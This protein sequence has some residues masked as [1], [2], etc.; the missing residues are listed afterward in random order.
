MSHSPRTLSLA[1]V[2]ILLAVAGGGIWWRV[3]SEAPGEGEARAAE[4]DPGAL[5][6]EASQQFST[7]VAQPVGAVEV[8]RDTLWIKVTAA[9][10]AAAHRNAKLVAR[11]EGAAQ[12]VPVRENDRV[13]TGRLLVRIDS[14]EYALA[15]ARAR[16]VLLKA[17]AD[18]QQL[19]LFDDEIA[20]PD[21][22]AERERLARS[23]SGLDE[24]TVAL[25]EAR[26]ALDR[27]SI[28]A[29]FPGRVANL[30]VVPGQYVSQG[31]E[32][33]TVVEL[34]PIKV[35]V[36]VLEAEI[37]YLE[38]G[39]R[40]DVTFAAFPGEVFQ[41]RVETINPVVD[42]ETRTA[43]VT[44]RLPNRDGRVKPG[45]YARVSLEAQQFAD[46]IL[47]PR[48]AILE[49]D[50]RTMLFVF[51]G[52]G[53]QGRA[54]WRYVTTGLENDSLVEIVANPETDMVEPGDRVL[55]EGHHY[56]VHDATVRIL[57]TGPTG[58]GAGR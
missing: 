28:R 32:I 47:V 49:R 48:S 22:R 55:V 26:L 10:E 39:R 43:R 54:K 37:G 56:L 14:T 24:A 12:S 17:E 7:D 20:D 53:D 13:D 21:V 57:E 31:D 36:Q 46:R 42:P 16:S 29:P 34:D 51:E 2:V 38:E 6:V 11:I 8:V 45:M 58:E 33:V 27:T 9:G 18:F 44:V 19:V 35:E 40:A 50:R 1:T 25:E 4:T 41:G 52:S 23:R 3:R 5:P 15:V 30:M